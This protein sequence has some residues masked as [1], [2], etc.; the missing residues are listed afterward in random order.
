LEKR[1]EKVK[2]TPFF[3]IHQK[4]GAKIVPFGGFEMPVQYS[5][6]IDEHK[7]VRN[8]VGVFDVSHMGEFFASGAGALSFL[9]SITVNDVSKLSP[10]KAQY[11]A[12]CYDDGGIVDDLLIYMLAERQYMIVVNA[13]NVDKDYAWMKEHLSADVKFENSSDEIALLAIQGPKS[14]ETLKKLTDVALSSIP[15]YNFV[16]GKL[17]GIDMTISRTGYTGELGFEI[18]FPVQHGKVIWEEI[19]EAGKEFGIAPIGLGARDTLRLEMG[20]CLYGNDIDQ[21]TN[22]LEAGLGWITK[23]NKSS[24]IAKPVLDKVKAEGVKRKL[25]GMI[26]DEKAVPRHGYSIVDGSTIGIITSG[27][28]SPSLEKGIAM[29]YVPAQY[30][31]VG[32]KVQIDVR[33]KL[34]AATVVSLPFLKKQ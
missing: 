24:F 26:L 1:T 29:G 16:T 8:A 13:S 5:G 10:G 9:Q 17:S 20:Y 21:T 14:L 23:L 25:V 31:P 22:T 2:R 18:Y 19:F 28:F 6:I 30:S 27:T 3:E 7:I 15:Y 11:S 32:S 12:M 4:L 33:G 34:M